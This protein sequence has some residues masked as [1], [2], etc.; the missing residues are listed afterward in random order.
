MADKRFKGVDEYIKAQPA[1]LRDNLLLLR[2][3][4]REAAPH[5]EELIR[6]NIPTYKQEGT[7]VYFAVRKEHIGFYPFRSAIIKFKDEI[8]AYETSQSTIKFSMNKKIPVSFIKKMVK[9]RLKENLEKAS[10]KK[11]EP[12]K[13]F[14]AFNIK[15]S[16]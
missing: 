5:A 14:S 4:I 9:F 12:K 7:L 10:L 1:G 2:K 8:H 13:G 15:N 6:Y 11:R 16:I 3:S